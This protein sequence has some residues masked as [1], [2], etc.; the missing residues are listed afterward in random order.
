M[1]IDSPCTQFD[2]LRE[3][4][5]RRSCKSNFASTSAS[6]RDASSQ[7]HFSAWEGWPV[8]RRMNFKIGNVVQ[9]RP[10][11]YSGPLIKSSN[12]SHFI[13]GP[14][15][16]RSWD[17]GGAFGNAGGTCGSVGMFLVVGGLECG[18]SRCF[19]AFGGIG[20]GGC[21]SSPLVASVIEFSS[22]RWGISGRS[23]GGEPQVSKEG[24]KSAASSKLG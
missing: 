14:N 17:S 13:L 15:E 10:L 4:E 24:G 12:R 20:M 2:G 22:G 11:L 7:V 3:P 9:R 23:G 16:C 1:Y 8:P 6:S 5:R 21:G 19:N 18:S